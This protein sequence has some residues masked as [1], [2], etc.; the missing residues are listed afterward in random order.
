MNGLFIRKFLLSSISVVTLPDSGSDSPLDVLRETERILRPGGKLVLG[1]VLKESPWGEFYRQK[2]QEG[3]RFYR[4]ATFYSRDEVAGLLQQAGFVIERIVSTL[5]QGPGQ[6]QRVEEPKEGY[7]PEAG[8]TI[9]VA[10]RGAPEAG[11]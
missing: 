10:G 2:K 5:F 11:R 3:H 6:V 8:F 1:L 4:Y 9:V 7:L